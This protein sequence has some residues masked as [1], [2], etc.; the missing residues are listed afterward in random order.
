MKRKRNE[1][2]PIILY[3]SEAASW[4]GESHPQ[5][6]HEVIYRVAVRSRWIQQQK[7]LTPQ[8]KEEKLIHAC[9]I[10]PVANVDAKEIKKQIQQAVDEH[11]ISADDAKQLI[12]TPK[13]MEKLVNTTSGRWAEQQIVAAK[14][15]RNNNTKCYRRSIGQND[16]I[17]FIGRIDGELQTNQLVEIK[18]RQKPIQ[19]GQHVPSY[20]IIQC[21]IYLFLTRRDSIQLIELG[22]GEQTQRSI[23][24]EFDVSLWDRIVGECEKTA[25][26]LQRL[27]RDTKVEYETAVLSGDWKQC[28]Q[29]L[30]NAE[31]GPSLE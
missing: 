13:T 17:R 1:W 23:C 14:Q 2:S 15:I 20:D 4:M 5:N 22:P 10:I 26:T 18:R 11:K 19:M 27:F 28:D 29:L 12:E 6:R 30:N 25:D 16:R 9:Q 7:K 8:Q 21:Y 31:H 24:F 3:A